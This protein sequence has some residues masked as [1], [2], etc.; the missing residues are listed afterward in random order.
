MTGNCL[1]SAQ[2]S[3]IIMCFCDHFFSCHTIKIKMCSFKSSENIQKEDGVD[4]SVSNNQFS[5]VLLKHY[6][7]PYHRQWLCMHCRASICYHTQNAT[8]H[9]MLPQLHFVYPTYTICYP[10][11]YCVG[12]VHNVLSGSKLSRLCTYVISLVVRGYTICSTRKTFSRFSS[13]SRSAKSYHT[14]S[15]FSRSPYLDNQLS[16]S[17]HTWTIDSLCD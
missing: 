10:R 4:R 17:I 6:I 1:V 11:A 7:S 5:S 8:E 16:E 14:A 15:K 9:K 3:A 2:I 12:R 13:T